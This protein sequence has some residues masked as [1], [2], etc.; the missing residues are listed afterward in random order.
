MKRNSFCFWERIEDEVVGVILL[1][2]GIISLGVSFAF[3]PIIGLP[4]P[5]IILAL[6]LGFIFAPRSEACRRV[7]KKTRK[8]LSSKKP[9]SKAEK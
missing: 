5:I 7:T 9:I 6:A 4:I 2:I 8:V 3:L 1:I